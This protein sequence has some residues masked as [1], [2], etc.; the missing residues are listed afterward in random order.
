ME[1]RYVYCNNEQTTI[2]I[3]GKQEQTGWCR[4]CH[5]KSKSIVAVYDKLVEKVKSGEY[6]VNGLIWTAKF[7]VTY[8]QS[9][10]DK[11][12]KKD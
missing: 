12:N 8:N 7:G 6:R 10:F 2:F 4:E 5:N 9:V 11:N 3:E 1:C